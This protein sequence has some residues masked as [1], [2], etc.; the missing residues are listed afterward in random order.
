MKYTMSSRIYRTERIVLRQSFRLP[1]RFQF[2]VKKQI[3]Y[4]KKF[5]IDEFNF[6]HENAAYG[7]INH[8]ARQGYK[9]KRSLAC[10]KLDL[11]VSI[12]CDVISRLALIL[13]L[14]AR[15][16]DFRV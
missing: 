11:A 7:S 14:S 10:T 12:E 4:L 1:S 8:N 9:H 13:M 15:Q 2:P 5:H 16:L 6:Y 3:L